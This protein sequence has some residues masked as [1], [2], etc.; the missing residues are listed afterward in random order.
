MPPQQM[1][2]IIT[3]RSRSCRTGFCSGPPWRRICNASAPREPGIGLAILYLDLDNVKHVN[4]SL[5]HPVGDALLAAVGERLRTCLRDT[6]LVAR[7]G[8]DEF[9]L[10]LMQRDV[11]TAAEQLG[12]RIIAELGRPYDLACA[13]CWTTSAP[14]IRR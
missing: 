5:G 8:G 11:A 13:S 9:A 12:R 10:L 1:R 2:T 3:T 7:L 4:D 14:A 6:D